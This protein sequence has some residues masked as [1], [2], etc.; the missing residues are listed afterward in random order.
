M[1]I[2]FCQEQAKFGVLVGPGLPFASSYGD[3]ITYAGFASPLS[4]LC[5]ELLSRSEIDF[6]IEFRKASRGGPTIPYT[7]FL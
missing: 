7:E 4:P 2:I 5:Y 3:S 1:K 6:L